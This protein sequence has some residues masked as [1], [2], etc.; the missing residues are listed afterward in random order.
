MLG[1]KSPRKK[2]RKGT[3]GVFITRYQLAALS[4]YPSSSTLELDHE[5]V[6]M[7]GANIKRAYSLRKHVA[8]NGRNKRE[9]CAWEREREREGGRDGG[10]RELKREYKRQK[11]R[12]ARW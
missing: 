10:E 11:G 4:R 2:E 6:R 1:L 9:A 5:R 3:K 8:R 7:F 12:I